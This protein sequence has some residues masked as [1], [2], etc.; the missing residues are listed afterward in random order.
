MVTTGATQARAQEAYDCF[1]T[2]A[3]PD[4][5]TFTRVRDGSPG[6]V[7]ELVREAHG[8]FLPDDWRY[9][10]IQSALEFID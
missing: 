3:R 10:C 6:W 1:E 9:G 2:A 5:E 8:D 7:G 4:G